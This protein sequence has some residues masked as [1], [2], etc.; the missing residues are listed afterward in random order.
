MNTPASPL[1]QDRVAAL[2]SLVQFAL[3]VGTMIVLGRAIGWPGILREPPGT[4]LAT[5]AAHPGGTLSGYWLY[6]ADAIALIPLVLA[7]HRSLR[8]AGAGGIANDTFAVLGLSAALLKSLG[9]VRWLTAAP[10]LARAYV[11]PAAPDAT[12]AMLEITFRG[13]NGYAGS[14]GEL[15][16]VQLAF[17]LWIAGTAS[18]LIR[19]GHRPLGGL[20]LVAGGLLV[21]TAARTFV[22]AAAGL[23]SIAVPLALAWFPWLAWRF[24]AAPQPQP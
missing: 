19:L 6:L 15:L 3:F 4:I 12:R 20:G 10:D 21:A 17:G 24:A 18:T 11:D 9:I 5:I 22:P 16:G 7:V 13:L 1:P 8:A 14:V 2:W 23:Q